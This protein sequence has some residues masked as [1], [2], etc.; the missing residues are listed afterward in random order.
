[1]PWK[2]KINSVICLYYTVIYNYILYIKHFA[3]LKDI[4]F[5]LNKYES[6]QSAG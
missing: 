3:V 1:M 4:E 2:C 5:V 6:T